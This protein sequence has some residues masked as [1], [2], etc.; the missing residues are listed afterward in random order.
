MQALIPR[1][2]TPPNRIFPIYV[3]QYY[4]GRCPWHWSLALLWH[5]D[6]KNRETTVITYEIVGTPDTYHYKGDWDT[7]VLEHSSKYRGFIE[8]GSVPEKDLEQF[9]HSLSTIEIKLHQEDWNCQNWVLTGI[10]RLQVAGWAST[11]VT[12]SWLREKLENVYL[13]HQKDEDQCGPL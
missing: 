12:E 6:E 1:P 11:D 4:L 10:R 13:L 8:I 2:I 3:A 7:V 5:Y 9:K